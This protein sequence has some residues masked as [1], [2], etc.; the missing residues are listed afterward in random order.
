MHK[1]LYPFTFML[2]LSGCGM[3][4]ANNMANY[5]TDTIYAV[6]DSLDVSAY[7]TTWTGEGEILPK[8]YR[9]ARYSD[10][11]LQHTNLYVSFDF[12]KRRL[13]GTA[14]ISL[15][16]HFYPT[17][18][19]VLDAKYL[20]IQSVD[21]KN[22]TS[23]VPAAFSHRDSLQL[24]IHLG[25]IIED[26]EALTTLKI[27]YTAKPYETTVSEGTAVTQDRGLYFINHDLSDPSKPMQI[28]TQGETE[29]SS[30]WFPTIDA[31][32][33]KMTQ[34]ICM[35]V[36]DTLLTLSN[37]LKTSSKKE[38]GGLRTDCWEQKLPHAP[39]LTMM[40]VGNWAETKDT[41]RGKQ[42]NYLVE[43]PF[44]AQAKTIFGKTP[45]MMSFFSDYTGV[46]FPWDKYSQVVV[47]DFVSGAMENTSATIHMEGLQTTEGEYRDETY[48]DYVSH[49][50]FHHWFGDLV[51]AESWSNITLNES[52]ATYGEYLWREHK[53]G[54]ANA[55]ELLEEFKR[56][57]YL[58]ESFSGN[59]P[60]LVRYQYHRADDVFDVI[61]YQKGAL[62]LHMLRNEIGDQAF[63]EGIKKYLTDNRF[64]TA[65]T[66]HLRLAMESITGRDLHPFFNQWYFTPNQ[67]EIQINAAWNEKTK[68]LTLSLNQRQHHRN[69]YLLQAP[70]LV[71]C[72]PS[73]RL[74]TVNTRE[75][76]SS[77]SISLPSKPD[78]WILD[79]YNSL[80][81]NIE[82]P[83]QNREESLDILRMLYSGMMQETAP[84]TQ[85]KLLK[86]A[87]R[88][89]Y[90][91]TEDSGFGELLK[92]M[93]AKALKSNWTPLID[94]GIAMA[95]DWITE[96][97]M[98]QPFK[99]E[100][101]QIAGSKCHYQSRISAMN[102][103]L[104][105]QTDTGNIL[106]P[107]LCNDPSLKVA[108]YAIENL[109]WN[110]Q[111]P[112]IAVKAIVNS[113]R[114]LAIA[115]A[116]RWLKEDSGT[117]ATEAMFL[118]TQNTEAGFAG[119]MEVFESF[120]YQN[121]AEVT[122]N[123]Q[124]EYLLKK[125]PTLSRKV[126]QAMAIKLK[127]IMTIAEDSTPWLGYAKSI[128][129]MAAQNK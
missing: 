104:Q 9:N 65:E 59:P 52:F 95:N 71:R 67:P 117:A 40:A 6:T 38:M 108:S 102:I 21:V 26:R 63:K 123:P 42:V 24:I 77:I 127:P 54:K 15:K 78:Y 41:W 60:P 72:G 58:M 48:E 112:A 10:W 14:E 118:L 110:N 101:T 27:I 47:R 1:P 80:L 129:E 69:T 51:T 103:L 114:S 55:D 23:W 64:G 89:R 17:D 91:N 75:R 18:T 30:R 87:H 116:K 84:Q 12:A 119:F 4:H 106:L 39:Y 49:E 34:K 68:E 44:A 81:V 62:I 3:F 98:V 105:G 85:F 11:K 61:S 111:H 124:W 121:M 53:Y 82:F 83:T 86:L 8:N 19:I 16:L 31:P 90:M 122:G 92:P 88:L 5:A 74:I 57:V 56:Y 93:I 20:D 100:L 66:D 125:C 7:D 96:E 25:N 37:G 32:N 2:L 113:P 29:S 120:I 76:N 50:L 35:T 33:Q 22:G 126:L 99:D 107:K 43:K 73:T 13:I 97:N 45:E 128:C 28:W 70:L 94:R 115:W 46:A 109:S 36:P 79:P